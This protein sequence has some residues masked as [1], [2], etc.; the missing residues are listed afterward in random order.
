MTTLKIAAFV[1]LMSTGCGGGSVERADVE[2]GPMPD[3]GTFTG[4]WF[5]PQYGEMQ[6]RQSGANVIGEY[7]QNERRGNIQGTVQGDLLR[8]EW[9]E[10][11]ELVAGRSRETRGRGYFQLKLDENGDF[12]IVGEWG[13]DN[14]EVGGGPWRAVRSR[15][16]RPQLSTDTV[17]EESTSGG[18]SYSGGTSGGDDSGGDESGGDDD[19]GGED[20][21]GEDDTGAD[22][23]EGLDL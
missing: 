14:S 6:M 22:D 4:V 13:H 17:S 18:S 20:S 9:R 19:S 2:P 10:K 16:R 11:R 1:A 7:S 21:G 15:T 5:S 12:V 3:N 23:L 8:Y